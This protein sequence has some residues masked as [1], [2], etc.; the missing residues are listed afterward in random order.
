M[1]EREYL[2]VAEVPGRGNF[3]GAVQYILAA[4]QLL[5]VIEDVGEEAAGLPSSA[6]ITLWS[7]RLSESVTS[8]WFP[9]REGMHVS[10]TRDLGVLPKEISRLQLRL[11]DED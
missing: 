1:G 10:L 11:S 8:E 2:W 4:D 3:T 5:F 9:L 7:S 6:C